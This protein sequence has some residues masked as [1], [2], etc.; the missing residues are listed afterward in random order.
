MKNNKTILLLQILSIFPL[1]I[2]TLIYVNS[3]VYSLFFVLLLI[4]S[5]TYNTYRYTKKL[6]LISYPLLPILVGSFLLYAYNNLGSKGTPQSYEVLHHKI[7]PIATF[8]FQNEQNIDQLCYN[9][10]INKK[11]D[12]YLESLENNRWKKI[13]QY[14]NKF[15]YSFRW[16]CSD[17]KTSTSKIRLVTTKNQMM[18]NELHFLSKENSLSYTT[19]KKKLN[20]E[21]HIA[22]D[23]SYY[24][25]MFFD[26]IYHSRTA[27]EI[28][29]G[30]KVYENTHPYLGKLLI[31]PGIKLFEMTPFGWRFTNVLFASFLILV[32]YYFSLQ[33]FRKKLFAFTASFLV[34]YSFM[35][36]TQSRIGLIDTF[37]VLFVFIS[38]F[39]LYKFIQ[40]QRLRLLFLS[41]VFFGLASAVKW[42]AVF[43]A[44]GFVLT[45]LYLL[46]VRYPLKKQ[47]KGYKLI[48]YG[49]LSY[50]LLA[51]FVYAL[52]FYDIYIQT[53]S[54]EKILDYQLNMFNYH[55][56]VTSIHPYG[57]PWWSWPLNYKPMCYY[58]EEVGVL[59]SSINA[60]GNPAIF[61]TGT[62]SIL[63]LFYKQIKSSTLESSFI[64]LAFMGLFLPYMFIGRQ[65][66]IYHFYYAVPF[67]ILAIVYLA[68][69]IIEKYPQNQK[70]LLFYLALTSILFLA[71]Y[72][73]LTGYEVYKEY[74]NM[75]RWLPKWWL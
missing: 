13:Y 70:Y 53:G 18:L 22:I 55:S 73:A 20:D 45:A 3:S 9:I 61:W 74:I 68:R 43:A 25:G 12:F 37:G 46:I 15:P 58:R 39:Y 14:E 65:M 51:I 57:S 26:E 40:E 71:Y 66:F 42:T 54:L 50:G 28:M 32:V 17:I 36:L 62:I 19:D 44:L 4:V 38:Y 49:L 8:T 31:I 33:I 23:T 72:P 64:L 10:G 27:Y 21:Q 7:H 2:F 59:Y 6:Q 34:T 16:E 75:L 48:L 35:H 52:T 47:F 11:V 67:M 29:R 41:G 30:I 69:D 56:A 24:S 1:I 63:Y 5:L 60:F